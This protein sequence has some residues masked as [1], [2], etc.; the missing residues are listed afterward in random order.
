MDLSK[1]DNSE[2]DPGAGRI[3]R[4]TWYLI[5]A[6]IFHSWLF[7][8]SGLKCYLL[9]IFGAKLGVGVVIKPRVNIKYPWNLQIGNYTWI[10]EGCWIDSLIKVVIGSNVCISQDAYLLTGNH[11]YKD[12]CFGLITS[13]IIIEDGVWVGAKCIVC[14]GT[15]MR[16]K[17][18][19]SVGSVLSGTSEENGIYQGNP[20][21]LVRHRKM[22]T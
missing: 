2:Y 12:P 15:V 14:P 20:A 18:I 1:Y 3:K 9:K 5:N 22:N 17:S 21:K 10:G 6:L 7:P 11:D 8:H 13:E 4:S 16:T 19:L